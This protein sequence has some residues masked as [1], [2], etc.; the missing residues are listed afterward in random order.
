MSDVLS[1]APAALD[2]DERE[3]ISCTVSELL[4][5]LTVLKGLGLGLG[6]YT[7]RILYKGPLKV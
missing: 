7:L 2:D 1:V 5:S 3:G 6:L 4:D